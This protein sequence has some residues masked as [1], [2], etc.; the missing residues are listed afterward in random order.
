MHIVLEISK[1]LTKHL[2]LSWRP[3]SVSVFKF[4]F[5]W[6]SVLLHNN[7]PDASSIFLSSSSLHWNMEFFHIFLKIFNL[8]QIKSG[9]LKRQTLKR[10]TSRKRTIL[11]DTNCHDTVSMSKF[12]R[13][14]TRCSK[15]MGQ[16][17]QFVPK[18]KSYINVRI[19]I[20]K[21]VFPKVPSCGFKANKHV[22][23][24]TIL[25]LEWQ[26]SFLKLTSSSVHSIRTKIDDCT[27]WKSLTS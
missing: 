9:V 7:A 26:L 11:S 14:I 12:S 27:Y 24:Q 13:E 20:F 6:S 1:F 22:C 3:L 19:Q 25:Y 21:Y 10:V 16:N 5:C 15:Q 17:L 23:I 4:P 18:F 2:V 8:S